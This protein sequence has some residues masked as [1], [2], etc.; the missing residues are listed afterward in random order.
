[1]LHV[2]HTDHCGPVTRSLT[3]APETKE[4]KHLPF[5]VVPRRRDRAAR[6]PRSSLRPGRAVAGDD[7][8]RA[9]ACIPPREFAECLRANFCS[10]AGQ[11]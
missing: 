1:M 6:A 8:P 10:Q 5:L 11:Q 4:P 7:P 2:R 9:D 3:S